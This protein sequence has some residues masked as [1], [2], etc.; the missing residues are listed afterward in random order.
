MDIV[1]NKKN[2]YIVNEKDFIKLILPHNDYHPDILLL[3]RRMIYLF[4]NED[5]EKMTRIKRWIDELIILHHSNT[6][7]FTHIS[8]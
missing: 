2:K 5:Y 4:R 6:G 1:E 8:H 3:K 7:S